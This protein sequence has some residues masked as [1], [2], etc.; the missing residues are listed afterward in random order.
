MNR[1]QVPKG[2][3]ILQED[4]RTGGFARSSTS[5]GCSRCRRR[6]FALPRHLP[7]TAHLHALALVRAAGAANPKLSRL[8]VLPISRSPCENLALG[9]ERENLALRA[10]LAAQM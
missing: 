9:A 6:T 10:E 4:G 8:A 3:E 7:P 2:L 1:K 5:I